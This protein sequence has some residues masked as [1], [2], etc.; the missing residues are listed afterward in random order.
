MAAVL[1]ACG[2]SRV[3]AAGLSLG[4]YLS[5]AFLPGLPGPGG[6]AGAV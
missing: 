2:I 3:V 4:G 6:R 1:D 5:L